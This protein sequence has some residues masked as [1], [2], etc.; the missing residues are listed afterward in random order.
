MPNFRSPVANP[1][2]DMEC[3][4]LVRPGSPLARAW[5]FNKPA[6]GIYDY[7]KGLDRHRLRFGDGSSQELIPAMFRDVLLLVDDGSALVGELFD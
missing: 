1:P 3:I 2:D 7:A 6:F 4:A 5:G